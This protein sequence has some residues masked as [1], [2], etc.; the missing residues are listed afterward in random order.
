M[1]DAESV[2]R[3]N[4]GI[5]AS[6]HWLPWRR[7]H[8]LRNAEVGDLGTVTNGDAE[9]PNVSSSLYD[10]VTTLAKVL[11]RRYVYNGQPY[12]LWDMVTIMFRDHM[13]AKPKP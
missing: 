7:V 3:D 11:A 9:N 4:A 5:D 8:L 12:D 2:S 6:G 1:A 13:D 10:H